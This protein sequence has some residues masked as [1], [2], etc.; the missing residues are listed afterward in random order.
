M[1]RYQAPISHAQI[2]DSAR[3]A[4]A[5]RKESAAILAKHAKFDVDVTSSMRRVQYGE[6]LRISEIQNQLDVARKYGMISKPVTAKDILP[7]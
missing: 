4:N 2:Y 3:W 1:T 6:A 7:A 5:N